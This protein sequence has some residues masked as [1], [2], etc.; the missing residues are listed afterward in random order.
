MLRFGDACGPR[1]EK[2]CDHLSPD[3]RF[4]AIF[5]FTALGAPPTASVLVERLLDADPGVR[6]AATRTAERHR[7]TEE[8]SLVASA[9]EDLLKGNDARSLRPAAEA[10]GRLRIRRNPKLLCALLD[11]AQSPIQSAAHRALVLLTARDLG[12]NSARWRS[13]LE[14]NADRPHVEWLISGM[15]NADP[16]IR[17]DAYTDLRTLT[18][19]SYDF[20]PNGNPSD[21]ALAVTRWRTWWRN[22]NSTDTPKAR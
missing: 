20:E 5:M 19:A 11:A 18:T 10:M 22:E 8:F 21:R 1:L 6:E 7:N 16:N 12:G 4:Y 15:E 3:I 13:W 17:A 2:L 14:H 9:L